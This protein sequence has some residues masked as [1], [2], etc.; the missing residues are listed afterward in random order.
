MKGLYAELFRACKDLNGFLEKIN[1]VAINGNI[2]KQKSKFMLIGRVCNGWDKWGINNCEE[3][4]NKA[5]NEFK[6]KDKNR[7]GWIEERGGALYNSKDYC[8]SNKPFWDYSKSIWEYISGCEAIGKWMENI[9]WSNLYKVAP[10]SGNPKDEYKRAELEICKKIL[11]REFELIKPTHIFMPV[12]YDGWFK[13]FEDIF[14]DV[15]YIGKNVLRGKNKNDVYVEATAKWKEAKVVVSCRPEFRKKE[16]FI[17][18]VI[19]Y[20]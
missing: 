2:D 17:K 4:S 14:S 5:Y 15:K 12:G 19:E 10:E 3:Y 6:D 1:F 13:D 18:A 7:W 8:V 11:A 16:D 20:F 9:A